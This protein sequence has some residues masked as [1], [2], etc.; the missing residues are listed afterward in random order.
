MK[1]FFTLVA[2]ILL[3]LGIM[4]SSH[5]AAIYDLSDDFSLSNP[6]GAWSYG[7]YTGG[8][9]ANTF[10]QFTIGETISVEGSDLDV[11][12]GDNGIDPNIIKNNG[13]SFTTSGSG[14]IDFNADEVTFGPYLGPTVARWT[15]QFD[16][17][18]DVMASFA[19]VQNGNTSPNAYIIADG[20]AFLDLG[21]L[22]ASAVNYNGTFTGIAGQ[23]IDF[24]VWGADGGN[25]TTEVSANITAVAVPE[26]SIIALFAVGLLGLGFARR[27]KV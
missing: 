15:A 22:T 4:G 12:H 19:T 25:K 3:A 27:R 17:T 7:K 2:G 10:T 9:D 11:W 20:L 16:G 26:P 6:N 24:V 5:A 23:W 21:T 14:V 18:F 8:L 13:E 1:R